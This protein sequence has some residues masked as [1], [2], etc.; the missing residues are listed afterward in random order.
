MEIRYK[1]V[2]RVANPVGTA[3]DF[4]RRQLKAFAE[5]FHEKVRAQFRCRKAVPGNSQ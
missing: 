4:V 3:S 5:N 1:D 2:L